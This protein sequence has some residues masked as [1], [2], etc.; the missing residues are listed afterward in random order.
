[1]RP[2]RLL[3]PVLLAAALLSGCTS[4]DA[5]PAPVTFTPPP[6]GALDDGPCALAA[7]DVVVLGRLAVDLRG[8][9]SPDQPL[10]D[11]LRDAQARVSGV[12]DGA[13]P[14]VEPALDRLVLRTGA[15]RIAADTGM[16]KDETLEALSEAYDE[17]V[18]ACSADGPAAPTPTAG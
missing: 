4:D 8:Q 3:P 7:E 2:S 14:A 13:G 11:E 12:A 18:G 17:A 5:A 10:R 15:V 9:A 1:M 6:P 16:L